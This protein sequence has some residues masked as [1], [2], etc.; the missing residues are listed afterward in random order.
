MAAIA[1][2][3]TIVWT[4]ASRRDGDLYRCS[5]RRRLAYD[6]LLLTVAIRNRNLLMNSAID[7]RPPVGASRADAAHI[8][9]M[10]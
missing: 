2:L 7:I 3:S 8:K 10:L 9:L 6:A 1:R 5:R 4:R